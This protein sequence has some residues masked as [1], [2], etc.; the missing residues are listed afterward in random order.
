MIKQYYYLFATIL[1]LQLKSAHIVHVV[2]A[3]AL[4]ILREHSSFFVSVTNEETPLLQHFHRRNSRMISAFQKHMKKQ[5]TETK[6]PSTLFVSVAWSNIHLR[7]H[8]F[9]STT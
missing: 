9:S 3:R 2:A 8:I 5:Y 6:T 1:V 4:Q 7:E